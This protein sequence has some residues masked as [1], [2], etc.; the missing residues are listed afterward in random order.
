MLAFFSEPKPAHGLPD[1]A[2]PLTSTTYFSFWGRQAQEV[3][4]SLSQGKAPQVFSSRTFALFCLLT[5]TKDHEKFVIQAVKLHI[6]QGSLMVRR[7]LILPLPPPIHG[8]QDGD[9]PDGKMFDSFPPCQAWVWL[10]GIRKVLCGNRETGFCSVSRSVEERE[11]DHHFL[12]SPD[13]LCSWGFYFYG[14]TLAKLTL[15]ELYFQLYFW[16]HQRP[17]KA[18]QAGPWRSIIFLLPTG[19]VT[20]VESPVPEVFKRCV[21]VALRD[22]VD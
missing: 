2:A 4:C 19:G 10:C 8:E 5:T 7:K 15:E 17:T 6:Y 3:I 11:R 20:N 21:G 13:M 18:S 22:M 9:F 1:L 16:P 14:L 12:T